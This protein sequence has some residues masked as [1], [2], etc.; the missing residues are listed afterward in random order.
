M[1]PVPRTPPL[2]D[3]GGFSLIELLVAMAAA[4]VVV[5]AALAIYIVALHQSTR[6]SDRE[7]ADQTGRTAMTQIVEK[8]HSSCLQKEFAPV[9]VESK[10]NELR[11]VDA[12]SNAAAISSSKAQAEAYEDRVH[13]KKESGLEGSLIDERYPAESGTLPKEFVFNKTTPSAKV[14]L[15]TNVRETVKGK[16]EL[17]IFRYFAY[18]KKANSGSET[19]GVNALEEV[20]LGKEEK[21]TAASAAKV[22]AVEVN[23]TVAARE[24]NA[25]QSH[26]AI[27][28][29]N[30]VVLAFGLPASEATFE[31]KPCQ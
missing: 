13:W 31:E 9:Q 4:T 25:F 12:A 21:L 11:F 8:L 30:E 6:I 27:P 17:P 15:A 7:Q 24:A 19:S 20:K 3:E 28:F 10:A 2:G 5:T 1:S 22:A 23:F 26:E 16:E 14:L 29:S 18:A